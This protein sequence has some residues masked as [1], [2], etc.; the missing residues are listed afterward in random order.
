[1]FRQREYCIQRHLKCKNAWY[2]QE[3]S[4]GFGMPITDREWQKNELNEKEKLGSHIRI[5]SVILKIWYFSPKISVEQIK[6]Y[7]TENASSDFCFRR[8]PV[9]GAWRG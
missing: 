4:S 6:G 5:F 1:M 2:I 9:Y 7:K 8:H 3:I